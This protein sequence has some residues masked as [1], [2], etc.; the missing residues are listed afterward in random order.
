MIKNK[1]MQLIL[2][3]TVGTS[4]FVGCSSDNANKSMKT[5]G[6]TQLVEH[7]SL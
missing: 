7:P 1:L 5:I 3:G 2:I 6:I 4:L